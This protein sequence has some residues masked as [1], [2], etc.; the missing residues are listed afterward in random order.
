M[1]NFLLFLAQLGQRDVAAH[2]VAWLNFGEGWL[3][4]C[5]QVFYAATSHSW[6]TRV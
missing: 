5:A 1:G 6:A 4:R 2:E 3:Y